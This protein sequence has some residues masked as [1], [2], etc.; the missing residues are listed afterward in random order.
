MA[1]DLTIDSQVDRYRSKAID[2][3]EHVP[4]FETPRRSVRAKVR[5]AW[6]DRLSRCCLIASGI[7]LWFSAGLAD[8][9]FLLPLL[10]LGPA[11]WWRQR[12]R[13]SAPEAEAEDWL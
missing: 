3:T 13:A 5:A 10:G 4:V 9:Q 12:D 2:A 7:S 1:N 11:L 6:D 8:P